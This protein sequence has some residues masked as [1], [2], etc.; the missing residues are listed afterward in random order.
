MTTV[1]VATCETGEPFSINFDETPHVL[2]GGTTGSGKSNALNVLVARCV[3]GGS[4]TS[5]IDLCEV[6]FIEWAAAGVEVVTDYQSVA[7]YIECVMDV[8]ASR[9]AH[10]RKHGFVRMADVPNGERLPHKVVIVDEVQMLLQP[11]RDKT[12][13]EIA[14]RC[15]LGLFHLLSLG[16]KAGLSM[17]L[18]TQ[19]PAADVIPSRLRDLCG[20]RV[21][22]RTET[23][24]VTDT[25]LGAGASSLGAEAHMISPRFPGTAIVKIDGS[26]FRRVRFPYFDMRPVAVAT[27]AD[28]KAGRTGTEGATSSINGEEGNQ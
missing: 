26:K 27:L 20:V 25:I 15:E 8:M 10:V 2:F 28:V 4:E 24:D 14:A 23:R 6:D 17:V 19:K 22:C 7:G 9:I 5:I 13:R 1:S 3:L 18:A 21:A 12:S 11:G 16:R